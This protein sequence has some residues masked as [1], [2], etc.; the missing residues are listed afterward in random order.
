MAGNSIS[1]LSFG[2]S[3][4]FAG[5]PDMMAVVAAGDQVVLRAN[6]KLCSLLGYSEEEIS[7]RSL[8]DFVHPPDL[9]TARKT[10]GRGQAFDRLTMRVCSQAGRQFYLEW[11]GT[12][13]RDGWLYLV[14]RDVT[15]ERQRQDELYQLAHY[16]PVTGLPNRNLFQ[17]RVTQGL[18]QARR[19]DRQAALIFIDLDNFKPVNDTYGHSVGDQVLKAVAE[20]LLG[21]VRETDTVTRRGGDE[22]VVFLS[23]LKDQTMVKTVRSRLSRALRSPV[24][25]LSGGIKVAASCGTAVF[26]QDGA[27]ME[28]LLRCSDERMY[29]QKA[30]KRE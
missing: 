19:E 22:F 29:K 2:V 20:R 23:M 21:V 3:E 10:F 8:F 5:S 1:D 12:P 27:D 30:A 4:L 18:A 17:D 13:V 25:T 7:G 24:K 9:L 11:S 6:A 15:E 16:D 28:E 26:P 14:A